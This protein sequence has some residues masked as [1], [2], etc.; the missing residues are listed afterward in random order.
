[1]DISQFYSD[2]PLDENYYQINQRF[3]NLTCKDIIESLKGDIAVLENEYAVD[4]TVEEMSAYQGIRELIEKLKKKPETGAP[5]QGE[6]FNT[7][8]RGARLGKLYLRSAASGVG[9]TRTMVGDSCKM[10]YPIR[11]DRKQGKWVS[12]GSCEK[13][14]Y[15]ATEQDTAEIQTMILAYLTDINEEAFL[16]GK[17]DL[18]DIQLITK[19]VDIMEKY[20]DNL[21]LARI[22][23]PSAGVVKNVIRKYHK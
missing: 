13:V 18:V 8:S 3:N 19:A 14:L 16:Y 1:M 21:W 10:A 5:M 12:T 7:V 15:I 2:N 17:F 4:T 9:K 11:Y 23:D 6:Y 20:E 22:S